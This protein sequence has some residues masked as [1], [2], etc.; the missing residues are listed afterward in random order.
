MNSN[1]R[2]A[3]TVYSLGTLFV[4]GIYVQ[5][6]CIKEIMTMIII[7]KAKT[8]TLIDVAIPA[9]R[10]V[11]QREAEKKLKYKS[12]C[13]EKQGMSNLKCT[14][15]PVITLVNTRN[16]SETKIV[17]SSSI[18]CAE[19]KYGLRIQFLALVVVIHEVWLNA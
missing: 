6:P 15:I 9:D 2:I 16:V 3:A 19:P 7:I 4:S 18:Q 12:L 13:I 14:I 5:I 1:K 10:N 17:Y 11:V 8:C